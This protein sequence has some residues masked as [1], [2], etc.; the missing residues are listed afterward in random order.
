MGPQAAA[1]L[2][3][4]RLPPLAE[5]EAAPTQ[6][7]DGFDSDL[8]PEE[9]RQLFQHRCRLQYVRSVAV[10]AIQE[11]WD[12]KAHFQLLSIAHEVY[13]HD[14]NDASRFSASACRVCQQPCGSRATMAL[15]LATHIG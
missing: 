2:L 4:I 5:T 6:A 11:S 10:Q 15:H 9:Q 14:R 1:S 12:L 7:Y 3:T 8:S 13:E